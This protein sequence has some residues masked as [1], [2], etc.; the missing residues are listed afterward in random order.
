MSKKTLKRS[1][2]LGALMAF[3]I[4]GSAMAA[5]LG[6]TATYNGTIKNETELVG[7]G[8]TILTLVG[9]TS[10][11]GSQASISTSTGLKNVSNIKELVYKDGWGDGVGVGGVANATEA[12]NGDTLTLSNI[13]SIRTEGA[14]GDTTIMF[15]AQGSEIYLKEIGDIDISDTTRCFYAQNAGGRD[16][17][18]EIDAETINVKASSTA[19]QAQSQ[20]TDG[21][22]ASIDMHAKNITL[23]VEPDYACVSIYN[24]NGSSASKIKIEADERLSITGSAAVNAQYGSNKDNLASIEL[25]AKNV[26]ITNNAVKTNDDGTIKYPFA[27]SARNFSSIEVGKN[28]GFE[29]ASIQGVIRSGNKDTESDY[30]IVDVNFGTNGYFNGRVE[31]NQNAVTKLDFGNGS[32]WELTEASTITNVTFAKDSVLN[33]DGNTFKEDTGA[34]ALNGASDEASLTVANGAKIVIVNGELDGT[35]NVAKDFATNEG[36]NWTLQADNALWYVDWTDLD[37]NTNTLQGKILVKDGEALVESGVATGENQNIL[38][39]VAGATEGKNA[40]A[41]AINELASSGASTED[42]QKGAAA[43]LQIG[44]AGGFTGNV[45]SVGKQVNNVVGGR[46]SFAGPKHGGPRHRGGHGPSVTEE[47]NGGAIWAQYVHG[48]DKVDGIDMGGVENAYESQ[49]NGVVLGADFKQVGSYASGIAF[50]YGEGDSHSKKN[51]VQSDSEFDFWGV[52]YYGAVKKQDTN[53]IFDIGYS[54]SDSDVE[55][56]VGGNTITANPEASTWSAGVKVEKLIDK[57]AVQ[58]VPYAGLRYMS[59]DT[60]EYEAKGS[61][62]GATYYSTERQDI[63]L[64]PIGVSL[65]QENVYD[66]GWIV[67]PKADLSY[68]WAMGDTDSSMTVNMP[69]VGSDNLGYTVMDDGSFMATIGLDAQK[70]DWTFGVAYSYQK[71][72]STR[73]DRWYVNARYS[74]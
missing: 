23:E 64:L 25:N 53:F 65:S 55:Q 59:I 66:S 45:V 49:F 31:T 13:D 73:S 16:A 1:L 30:S 46:N 12:T 56:V 72:D 71:G 36:A 29:N 6:D 39:N 63:W 50:N 57:G 34:Y 2:A 70:E 58:I 61:T 44:E 9:N 41:D 60:D 7:N 69:G 18:L 17:L 67:T 22:I 51:V 68:T 32:E 28:E 37:E 20:N 47:N 11:S 38:S 10:A 74:F 27:L 35:Y 42:I 43:L 54:E 4:T 5:N 62:A 15:H 14:I 33:I 26:I 8:Y 3:V 40:T 52:S 24:Y 48:K 21:G 19:V